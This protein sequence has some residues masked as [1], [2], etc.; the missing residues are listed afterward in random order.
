MFRIANSCAADHAR[1]VNR[2][3]GATNGV[4][5]HQPRCPPARPPARLPDRPPACTHKRIP[6]AED[7]FPGGIVDGGVV[8]V[9]Q[10]RDG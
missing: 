4:H 8:A 9:A 5:H 6:A 1:M 2:G 3:P 7:A 10:Q